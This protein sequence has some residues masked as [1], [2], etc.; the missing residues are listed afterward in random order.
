VEFA[1]E[2]DTDLGRLR[3]AKTNFVAKGFCHKMRFVRD[4]LYLTFD[5]VD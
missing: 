1:K 5:L 4:E 3:N 2:T